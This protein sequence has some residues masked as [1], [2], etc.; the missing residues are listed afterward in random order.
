V[1]KNG[2]WKKEGHFACIV[3]FNERQR[4]RRNRKCWTKKWI[5]RRALQGACCNLL[6]ELGAASYLN[7]LRLTK[8]QKEEYQN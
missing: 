8:D 1:V 7:Y 2:F 3:H 6:N 4:M 5:S